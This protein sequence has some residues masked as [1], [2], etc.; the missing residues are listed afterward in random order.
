MF[1]QEEPTNRTANCHLCKIELS[2]KLPRLVY[3]DYNW[4]W[5]TRYKHYICPE[6]AIKHK[7]DKD[8]VNEYLDLLKYNY[9]KEYMM[10]TKSLVAKTL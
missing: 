3:Y 9:N 10:Y 5:G 7:R 1:I 6:C 4:S 2:G 8:T